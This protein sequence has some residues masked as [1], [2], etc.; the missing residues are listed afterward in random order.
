MLLRRKGPAWIEQIRFSS[1][2]AIQPVLLR[3]E[4]GRI[5]A[6][7]RAVQDPA[8]IWRCASS[9]EGKSWSNLIQTQLP[10][11]L[12]AIAGFA[13]ADKLVVVYNHSTN[14][15]RDPLS[16]ATSIDGGVSWSAPRAIDSSSFE[17][18]YPSFTVDTHGQ[19]HGVYT[20]NRRMIK[21]VSFAS[22]DLP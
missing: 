2:K 8:V 5:T 9:D 1:D 7:F 21:Y 12:S 4:C 14:H 10:C 22:G 18:S 19:V 15:K 3:D 13:A 20:F 11:P 6:L 16:M 17:V